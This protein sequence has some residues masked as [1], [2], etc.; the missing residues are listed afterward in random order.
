MRLLLGLSLICAAGIMSCKSN[1]DNAVSGKITADTIRIQQYGG[2]IPVRKVY[3]LSQGSLREDTSFRTGDT[4]GYRFNTVL[5]NEKYKRVKDLLAEIP[6]QLLHEETILIGEPHFE[7]DG[8]ATYLFVY[9][10][11]RKYT[12]LLSDEITTLPSYLK[13]FALQIRQAFIDLK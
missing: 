3:S 9:L 12:Y 4:T 13:P 8:T 11:G 7:R 2:M 1:E 10:H 5:G 6:A